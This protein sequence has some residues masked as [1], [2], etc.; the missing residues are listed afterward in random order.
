MVITG[1]QVS[2]LDDTM[3]RDSAGERERG[4][5]LKMCTLLCGC[6]EHDDFNELTQP[7]RCG[8]IVLQEVNKR[9]VLEGVGKT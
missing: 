9:A 3:N 6:L 5:R 1:I 2:Y 4:D 8:G 7:A